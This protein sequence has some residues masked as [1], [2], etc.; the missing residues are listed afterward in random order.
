MMI[1]LF[2]AYGS[3]SFLKYRMKNR[4]GNVCTIVTIVAFGLG[5]T[6]EYSSLSVTPPSIDSPY[7]EWYVI[8]D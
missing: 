2:R 5:I 7:G 1:H 3:R 4:E 8:H 6:I